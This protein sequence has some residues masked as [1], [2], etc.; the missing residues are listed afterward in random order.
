MPARL[1]VE[2]ALRRTRGGRGK[3]WKVRSPDYGDLRWRNW[4]KRQNQNLTSWAEI[5]EIRFARMTG[6]R[7]PSTRGSAYRAGERL[8]LRERRG[9]APFASTR[10]GTVGRVDM[11]PAGSPPRTSSM[12]LYSETGSPGVEKSGGEQVDA[13]SVFKEKSAKLVK[14][15]HHAGVPPVYRGSILCCGGW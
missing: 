2:W 3:G 6:H 9:L 12:H 4:S 14:P 7:Q 15:R 10:R 11:M 1:T 5:A 8:P 13:T